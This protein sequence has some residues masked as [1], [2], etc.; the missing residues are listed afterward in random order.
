MQQQQTLGLYERRSKADVELSRHEKI[1]IVTVM[2][3]RGGNYCRALRGSKEFLTTQEEYV[4][5]VGDRY[6]H[7]H[8]LW[9]MRSTPSSVERVS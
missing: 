3:V 6:G 9:S 4:A 8:A 1:S 2:G 5:I 7:V